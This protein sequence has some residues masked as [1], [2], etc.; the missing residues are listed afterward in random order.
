MNPLF[1][2]FFIGFGAGPEIQTGFEGKLIDQENFLS[3]VFFL[4]GKILGFTILGYLLGLLGSALQQSTI[5]EVTI[6]SFIG[7]FMIAT[8][9][10]MAEAHSFFKYFNFKFSQKFT[11]STSLFSSAG[12]GLKSVLNPSPS[13]QAMAMFALGLVTRRQGALVM[14]SFALGC[15]AFLFLNRF[16]LRGILQPLSAYLYAA[17][18]IAIFILGLLAFDHSLILANSPLTLQRFWHTATGF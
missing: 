3:T 5:V 9:L 8:A 1:L 17:A 16:L 12:N 2:P 10:N 13:A 18:T 11:Q 6:Q 4:A 7:V 14:L 15:A